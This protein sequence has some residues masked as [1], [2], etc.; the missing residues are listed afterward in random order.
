MVRLAFVLVQSGLGILR[1]CS[2]GILLH[3]SL[4]QPWR[5][6]RPTPLP[7]RQQ[8]TLTRTIQSPQRTAIQL[9]DVDKSTI[10]IRITRCLSTVSLSVFVAHPSCLYGSTR[11]TTRMNMVGESLL[12]IVFS[13]YRLRAMYLG[14]CIPCPDERSR[15]GASPVSG[16]DLKTSRRTR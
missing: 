8:M 4:G 15:Y 3:R 2:L 5:L 10:P 14:S 9:H 1:I 11:N 13:D 6:A 12:H 7:Y 16:S